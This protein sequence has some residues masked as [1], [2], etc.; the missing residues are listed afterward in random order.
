MA[1]TPASENPFNMNKSPLLS[2]EKKEMFH[3]FVAKNL[4]VTKQARP[5]AMTTVAFSCTRVKS[6]MQE[7]WTK[8][9][10]LMKCLQGTKD[11]VSTLSATGALHMKWFTDAAFA[12]HPDAQRGFIT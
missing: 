2:E 9:V 4:F 10:R 3:T 7:D 8:S 1:P 5:D 12:V 11:M 6:P